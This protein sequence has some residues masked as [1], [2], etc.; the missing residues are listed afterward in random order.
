[1]VIISGS[2]SDSTELYALFAFVPLHNS[3]F[4][5]KSNERILHSTSLQLNLTNMINLGM[6]AAAATARSTNIVNFYEILPKI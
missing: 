6:F 2:G 1:M 5:L 4:M 3:L